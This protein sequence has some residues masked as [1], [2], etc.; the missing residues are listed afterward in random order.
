MAYHTPFC[1]S[2]IMCG[3]ALDI[4]EEIWLANFFFFNKNTQVVKIRTIVYFKIARY[5]KLDT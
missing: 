3:K 5:L 2:L 4:L 1:K